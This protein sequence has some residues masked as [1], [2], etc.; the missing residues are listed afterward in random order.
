[1]KFKPGD[2]VKYEPDRFLC[3]SFLGEYGR[4]P[5]VVSKCLPLQGQ[6]ILRTIDNKRL[7]RGGKDRD[8]HHTENHLVSDAFLD[9]ARKAISRKENKP[10]VQRKTQRKV[11]T[12][13]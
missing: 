8:W 13:K 1:M 4:G 11:A 6:V 12:Q 2:I 9:A 5:F 7:L 3:T 10:H